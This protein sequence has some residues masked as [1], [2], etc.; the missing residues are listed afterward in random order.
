MFLA[1][2]PDHAREQPQRS[3]SAVRLHKGADLKRNSIGKRRQTPV[4]ELTR[5]SDIKL[6]AR[7]SLRPHPHPLY[8]CRAGQLLLVR[9]YPKGKPSSDH[10][11]LGGLFR[12]TLVF[13]D[14]NTGTDKVMRI[15]DKDAEESTGA[16]GRQ[17]LL[18]S[19]DPWVVVTR[20]QK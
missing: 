4:P 2:T 6:N 8:Q 3:R 18:A 10:T 11:P 7:V 9:D 1:Q 13:R 15:D 5:R 12:M 17:S 14:R 19:R 16:T 20:D